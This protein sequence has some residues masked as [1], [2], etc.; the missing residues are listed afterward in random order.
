MSIKNP[1]Q[2]YVAA[3]SC[4][5]DF[6][7]ELIIAAQS[8]LRQCCKNQ[9]GRNFY[10]GPGVLSNWRT[11]K[12]QLIPGLILPGSHLP[13]IDALLYDGHQKGQADDKI[14]ALLHLE[15]TDWRGAR[16]NSPYGAVGAV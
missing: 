5:N 12:V 10:S 15:G 7:L 6:H 16:V 1:A 3:G 13:S 11:S 4:E 9:N 2:S 14:T 8:W